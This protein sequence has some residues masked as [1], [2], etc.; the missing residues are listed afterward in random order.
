MRGKGQTTIVSATLYT[1]VTIAVVAIVL[2]IGIPYLTKLKEY[3]EIRKGETVM[4]NIDEIIAVVAS[5]GKGSKRKVNISLSDPMDINGASDLIT[6]KKTTTAE[7]V[8]PRV[9]KT[10]GNY[11]IGTNIGVNAYSSTLGDTNVLV[12][13]NEYIYFAVRKLDANTPITLDQLIVRIMRKDD[14]S[15]LNAT[16]DFYLDNDC[17]AT[18]NVSTELKKSGYNLGK[19][20]IIANVY[21]ASYSYKINFILESG[22]DFV[23]I[24][25]SD[26]Q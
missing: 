1:L 2:Q 22:S 14:N 20:H 16:L 5:E 8:S 11:F 15:V 7:I 18:V 23:R 3:G 17:G 21:G 6:I 4:K 26:L 13:E 9:K 19:G 25:I 24:Y 10:Q 12:I